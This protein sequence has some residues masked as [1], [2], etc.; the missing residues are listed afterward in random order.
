MD[1]RLGFVR[2]YLS[3]DGL[4]KIVQHSIRREHFKACRSEY[5]WEDCLMSGLAVFGFKMPSLLQFEKD[6]TSEP[7]IRRNLRTLYG[8]EKAPSDTCMRERL[9]KVQPSQLRRPYKK[10]F[11]SLQR[12]KA[13]EAFR[14][15]D[16]HHIISVDGTGQY[17]SEK[18]HCENC[19]EKHHRNGHT[20]YYHHL[21]GAVLVHPDHREV[22]PLAPE[23]IVKGDGATKNDCERNASKRLL[24]TLRREHPH[25]KILIV[26]DGL[27][28]NY[29]HLSL[30]DSLTMSYVI[31]VKEG[32]H[33]Y[34]FDWIKD[35]PP[36]THEELDKEGTLH[37]FHYFENVPLNDTHYDYRV[38]V[39]QYW[40]TKKSGKKQ[41]FSWITRL[42][43]TPK[44]VYQIMRA[45]R[46]RW[47]IENE[48]FNTLKNQGYHFEHN[49]G[50]GY[51]NLCSVMT[52]LMMLAFL[53]DQVQQL[54]CKVY[55]KAR[56]HVGTLGRLFEKVRNR[57]DIAVW[58]S[59]FHLYTFIGDPSSR[60][61]PNEK[62]WLIQ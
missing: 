39:V 4:I 17:S 26:E 50:H 52:M 34:L 29:P 11:A 40:E 22:I 58:D 23:P 21:L 53:I 32:D 44:N 56:Q 55:Q 24:S 30:L 59:W 47:R 14:Y 42:A 38:N 8:I 28:A 46:S 20:E 62:G 35:L 33:E 9:D 27:A 48:T 7:W 19:C 49:Y 6:K 13:L 41:Y 12:G 25:L 43:I 2:K 15:L 18:V 54:C 1:K 16:G 5:S 37:Q 45:G 57:I 60:P 51:K 10:I 61:P 3:A 36:Q 31:G